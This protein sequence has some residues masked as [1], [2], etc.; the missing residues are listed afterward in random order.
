MIVASYVTNKSNMSDTKTYEDFY[1]FLGSKPHRL[2]VMSRM[3]PYLTA[4]FLT[5]SLKNVFYMDNKQQQYKS[6]EA[7]YFEWE[8]ESNY[9]KRVEFAAVPDQAE[10]GEDIIMAFKERYYEKYDIFKIDESRQQCQVVSRPIRKAD[11]YWEY[12]VRIVDNDY[13]SVLDIDACQ[14]GMTTRF[15]SNAIIPILEWIIVAWLSD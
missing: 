11:D 5:E 15:Q 2:G 8:T 9:I 13:S 1:K 7:P 10:P 14:I 3:Y 4:S 12:T 6:L